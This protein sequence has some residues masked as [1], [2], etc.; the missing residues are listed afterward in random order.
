MSAI[1]ENPVTQADIDAWW[2]MSQDLAKL[3]TSEMLLRMKIFNG[4]FKEPVEG[5]NKFALGDQGWQI[6][7]T[8]VINRKIDVALLTAKAAQLR[9]QG[10]NIDTLI[11]Q[12]PEVIVSAYKKLK[13]EEQA[14]FDEVLD[15]APGSP[16]M[17]IE[18]P[19]KAMGAVVA[20]AD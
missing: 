1:P 7:A 19:K 10:L 18:L 20:G 8:Y 9:E 2:K 6:N 11:K 16:Q 4:V 12:K 5:T 14:L 13:P 3:K 15:I 17:K